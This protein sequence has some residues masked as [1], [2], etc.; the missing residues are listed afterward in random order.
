[1]ARYRLMVRLLASEEAAIKDLAAANGTSRS[2]QVRAL[3]LRGL[4]ASQP[5]DQQRTDAELQVKQFAVSARTF[6]VLRALAGAQQ[7]DVETI[8]KDTNARLEA[9][10]TQEQ[11][12]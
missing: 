4:A 8:V 11:K 9:A 5:G 7:I 2:E 1:M 3:V 6:A 10:L 12:P